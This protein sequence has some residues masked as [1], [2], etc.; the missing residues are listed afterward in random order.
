MTSWIRA[1][2]GFAPICRATSVFL[3]ST[4]IVGASRGQQPSITNDPTEPLRK[5]PI[6]FLVRRPEFG[7]ERVSILRVDALRPHDDVQAVVD[8]RLQGNWTLT[9]ALVEAGER[10]QVKSWNLW[11]KRWREKPIEVGTM[12]EGDDPP[13]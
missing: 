5:F 13:F 4:M 11:D 2:G 7:A 9:E 3:L 6:T 10:V 8:D 12:P 1:R